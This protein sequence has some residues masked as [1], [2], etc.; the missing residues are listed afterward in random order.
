MSFRAS[1][2]FRRRQLRSGNWRRELVA[3]SPA[4]VGVGS[5]APL[6]ASVEGV[7]REAG[8]RGSAL[9]AREASTR[10]AATK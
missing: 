9:A 1:L 8:W 4:S 5:D 3:V 2:L 6:D 7:L 10:L